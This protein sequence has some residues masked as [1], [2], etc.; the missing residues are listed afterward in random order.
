M[1][2]NNHSR[3]AIL[4]RNYDPPNPCSFRD[5]AFFL[6]IK[7]K[8]KKRNFFFIFTS[9]TLSSSAGMRI[10]QNDSKRCN[11]YSSMMA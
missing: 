1:L 3:V 6:K 9:H 2:S 8:L 11:I 5:F 4:C 7:K 10:G